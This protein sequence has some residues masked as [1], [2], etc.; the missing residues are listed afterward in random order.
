MHAWRVQSTRN[1]RLPYAQPWCAISHLA[2]E[3]SGLSF[4][5]TLLSIGCLLCSV[6]KLFSSASLFQD[7]WMFEG[8]L[9]RMPV[10]SSITMRLLGFALVALTLRVISF[11]AWKGPSA[12]SKAKCNGY[13]CPAGAACFAACISPRC[14]QAICL[15]AFRHLAMFVFC[16]DAST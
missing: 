4:L 8:D 1:D 6:L 12:C 16:S 7:Q 15:A 10:T 5:A 9:S 2:L 11:S 14:L 3:S 13:S